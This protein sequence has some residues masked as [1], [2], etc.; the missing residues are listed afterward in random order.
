MRQITLA[1]PQNKLRK[2]LIKL[3][4]SSDLPLHFNKTGNKEFTN[5]QRIS[6]I[7]LFKRSGKSLRQFIDEEFYESNWVSWLGLKKIPK[8]SPLHDWLNLFNIKLIRKL[9]NFSIDKTDL[10]VTA[11]DSTG[12]D[13]F[14]RSRHYK[15]RELGWHLI[16]YNIKRRIKL[17]SK[18]KSQT[19]LFFQIKILVF[20]DRALK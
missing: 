15:K 18:E 4:Y 2:Q 17:S 7:I 9:I 20:P 8:K 5:Y 6:I 14:R 1:H 12:I 19:F 11:I 13:S 10:K 16:F 3:F